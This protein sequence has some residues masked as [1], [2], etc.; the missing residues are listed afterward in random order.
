MPIYRETEEE[1][2]IRESVERTLAEQEAITLQAE[3]DHELAMQKGKL[4]SN[5]KTAIARGR[6]EAIVEI[7]FH[8]TRMPA[9]IL[10]MVLCAP[11]LILTKREAPQV[12]ADFFEM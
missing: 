5:S 12:V 1:R 11:I 8:I 6:Q 3:R 2:S 4:S 7:V 9:Y 10:F